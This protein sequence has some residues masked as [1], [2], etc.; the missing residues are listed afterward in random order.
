M[1]VGDKPKSELN[2]DNSSRTSLSTLGKMANES[3]QISKAQAVKIPLNSSKVRFMSNLSN[4]SSIE[5]FRSSYAPLQGSS[6]HKAWSEREPKLLQRR[7]SRC[8]KYSSGGELNSGCMASNR[9][10]LFRLVALSI[11]SLIMFTFSSI[12]FLSSPKKR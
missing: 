9:K 10:F 3:L 7:L 12:A 2:F 1:S 11:F 8:K 4:L 5:S 6:Q